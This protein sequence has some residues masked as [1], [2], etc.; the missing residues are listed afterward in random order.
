[1]R[2]GTVI[3]VGSPKR[4]MSILLRY[5]T[6][7]DV[8]AM[9]NYINALSRERTFINRQG[10][11]FSYSDE[12]KYVQ[13]EI[14]RI[15]KNKSVFL[16]LF[17]GRRLIGCGGIALRDGAMSHQA[18]LG[19]SIAKEFRDQGLG[20]LLMEYL[21]R[22]AKKRLKGIRIITLAVFANNPRAIALYKKFGFKEHGLLRKG[23]FRRGTYVDEMYMHRPQ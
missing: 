17:S 9:Q 18:S 7:R 16:L 4:D 21:H 13:A 23:L 10:E 20:T 3:Y 11:R 15:K 12:K 22:E 8:K 5:P 6:M 2:P 14:E 19:I 1:M